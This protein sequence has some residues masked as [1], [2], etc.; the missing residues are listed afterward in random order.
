MTGGSC[1][2]L[3][4]GQVGRHHKVFD[5]LEMRLK[6]LTKWTVKGAARFNW[7]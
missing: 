3:I 5:E 1:F 7:F 2:I 4:V 6:N